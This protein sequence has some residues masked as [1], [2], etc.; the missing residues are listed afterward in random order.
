MNGI[1][2]L[3]ATLLHFLWQGI[4]IAAVYAAVRRSVARPQ[5]RYLLACA[6]LAAMAAAPVAAWIAL[7]PP[8]SDA[9]A[10][11]ASFP[12]PHAA[13]AAAGVAG[14]R[15]RFLATGYEGIPSAWLSW[16]A[17]VWMAGVVV[18][19]LRLVGG[20]MMAERLR[21][22]QVRH[23]PAQWQQA[24]D[25]LRTRLRISRPVQLLIS[26]LVHAPAVVGLF[27]PVVLMPVGALA[28]LPAEQVE[29]LLLHELAHIRRYDYLV[30]TIQSV[31]EA[32]LFYHPAVW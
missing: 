28:G 16:V 14:E 7:R 10:L 3:G 22:R 18:F 12:T 19:W 30:N 5:V 26:G 9:V 29:A 11:P 4:L 15:L 17:A 20:W 25:R 23:A 21:R 8:P 1:E 27:R 13:S 31:V 6:A 24:L 2:L 32:L